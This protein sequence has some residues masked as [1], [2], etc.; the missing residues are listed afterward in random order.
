MLGPSGTPEYTGEPIT[1]Y[2]QGNDA[3]PALWRKCPKCLDMVPH[4]QPACQSVT[5]CLMMRPK[6]T[7]EL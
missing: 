5:D 2:T 7:G 1:G 4:N 3:E 6:P